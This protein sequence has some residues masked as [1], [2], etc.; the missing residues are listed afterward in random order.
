MSGPGDLQQEI[1]TKLGNTPAAMKTVEGGLQGITKATVAANR[2][3]KD[4]Q[5]TATKGM[6]GFGDQISKTSKALRG[7]GGVGPLQHIFGHAGHGNFGRVAVAAGV[8]GLAL[9]AYNVVMDRHIER[10]KAGIEA[11]E[12][13]AKAIEGGEK[14]MK[15]QALGALSQ[16]NDIAL[17]HALGGNGLVDKADELA[18]QGIDPGQARRGV[19]KVGRMDAVTRDRAIEAAKLVAGSGGD[20]EQALGEIAG[21]RGLQGTL[22]GEGGEDAV[23]ERL[24][25]RQ[26]GLHGAK[27]IDANELRT[28]LNGNRFLQAAQET[29]GI[30][31]KKDEI[32]RDQLAEAGP[33]AAREEVRKFSDPV[34]AAIL[35]LNSRRQQE[36][37]VLSRL[38]E[39]QGGLASALANLG[40][41]VGGA[42]SIEQQKCRKQVAYGAS[43]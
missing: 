20:F 43:D 19:A 28:N 23:A 41:L 25:N 22:R 11:H 3:Q 38:A 12:E 14:Q 8:A 2:A 36:I 33:G 26:F 24:F 42:G 30:L 32:A 9:E 21:H 13:M 34:S 5:A 37:D 17:L 10:V 16:R 1:S 40:Q 29:Q 7:L 6:H 15:G 18:R 39:T 35:D 31:G 27:R 4:F